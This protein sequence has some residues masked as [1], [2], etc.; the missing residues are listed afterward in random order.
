MIRGYLYYR[1]NCYCITVEGRRWLII[2]I[3]CDLKHCLCP[4]NLRH[5]KNNSKDFRLYVMILYTI[6]VTLS[7]TFVSLFSVQV[8]GDTQSSDF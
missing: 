5:V 6:Y 3:N 4:H 1:H 7:V 8:V 2:C